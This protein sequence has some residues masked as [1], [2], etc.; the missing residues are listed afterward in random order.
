MKI[1]RHAQRKKEQDYRGKWRLSHKQ[2]AT[3]IHTYTLQNNDMLYFKSHLFTFTR[4]F[5]LHI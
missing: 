5:N 2:Y 4:A 3:E 1:Y